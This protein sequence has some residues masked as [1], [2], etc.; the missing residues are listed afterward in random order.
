MG[1][2]LTG[3]TVASTRTWLLQLGA[4]ITSSLQRVLGGDGTE[5]ALSLSTAGAKVTGT[6]Q[7]T[8]TVTADGTI[9]ASAVK[10]YVAGTGR[11]HAILPALDPD[12]GIITVEIDQT[13]E[14]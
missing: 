8:G 7:V 10:I 12:S 13:G 5:S 2:Q 1:N 4:A 9:K 14:A 3:R 11:Y 6:F